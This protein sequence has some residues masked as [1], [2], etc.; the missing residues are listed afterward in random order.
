MEFTNDD[1]VRSPGTETT[2]TYEVRKPSV[3]QKKILRRAAYMP[4]AKTHLRLPL[5]S[6]SQVNLIYK[7]VSESWPVSDSSVRGTFLTRLRNSLNCIVESHHCIT[8]FSVPHVTV[9]TDKTYYYHHHQTRCILFAR[10]VTQESCVVSTIVR[11]CAR[12]REIST[13]AR[14]TRRLRN[15]S[16]HLA[17]AQ[18]KSVARRATQ[19]RI[20][21]FRCS[22]FSSA[23]R[24]AL[25]ERIGRT[26]HAQLQSG[27]GH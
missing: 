8:P 25:G 7:Q 19:K 23:L 22:S 17:L 27:Q 5:R 3:H 13:R 14:F 9:R 11:S 15:C 20:F 10:V 16:V 26:T 12:R 1:V 2:E 18:Q 4:P 6:A 21:F 24:K